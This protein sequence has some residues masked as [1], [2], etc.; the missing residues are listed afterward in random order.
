MIKELLDE[1]SF[2]EIDAF[3]GA[4]FKKEA[5]ETSSLGVKG[6]FHGRSETV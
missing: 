3:Y 6:E 5:F 4:F 1:K 2:V